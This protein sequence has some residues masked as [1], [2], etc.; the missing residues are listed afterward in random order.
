VVSDQSRVRVEALLLFHEGQASDP[1]TVGGAAAA[2]APS[3]C[4]AERALMSGSSVE[5]TAKAGGKGGTRAGMV[6][7]SGIDEAR[8]VRNRRGRGEE[9]SCVSASAALVLVVAIGI[10]ALKLI[11]LAEWN[12]R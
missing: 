3:D 6:D 7:H 9:P 2:A 12:L 4:T 1:L 10:A 8:R 11:E 5:G